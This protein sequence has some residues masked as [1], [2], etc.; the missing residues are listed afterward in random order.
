MI[1]LEF[2]I[3]LI[4]NSVMNSEIIVNNAI[5]NRAWSFLIGNWSIPRFQRN[6]KLRTGL[7]TLRTRY[8][9]KK[10]EIIKTECM[11]TGQ[12]LT[13]NKAMAEITW[14]VVKKEKNYLFMNIICICYYLLCL[15]K[16]IYQMCC[17]CHMGEQEYFVTGSQWL[18]F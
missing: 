8:G 11:S 10:N 13:L 1:I 7:K 2:T 17:N 6:N 16:A 14:T 5:N 15:R 9:L 18:S 3:R 12:K 4:Y